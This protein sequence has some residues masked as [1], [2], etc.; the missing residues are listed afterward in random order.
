M[1]NDIACVHFGT[2]HG[3]S[4]VTSIAQLREPAPDTF[5]VV[6]NQLGQHS[7][8]PASLPVPAGWR[9]QSGALPRAGCLAAIEAGWRNI[10][11]ASV[12]APAGDH[13][14]GDAGRG[15]SFVHELFTR[16]AALRPDAVAVAA[17]RARVT[18]RELDESSG[19]LA[20]R[21]R[22]NGVGPEVI[23]GVHLERGIDLITA[24]LGVMKAGGGYL[25]LDPALPAERL[26]MMCAQAGPAVVLTAAPA[27]FPCTSARMLPLGELAS[28]PA[29]GALTAAGP[30]VRPRPDNVCYVIHTSGSTGD[31]KAV[32]V[33]Y[34][35]L[36]SV[37]G[38]LAA[39]YQ[40]GKEDR[41]AQLAAMAFDT[42][43]E[44]MFVA[45]TS[46]ARLTLAPSGTLAP[47]ELLRG[48]E[49]RAIT[50]VDL[51]PAYWHQML[52]LA[53]PDDERLRS[54]R[55]MITGGELADPADCRAALRAAPWARLLNAYGLT[56]TTITS[57]IFDVSGW[58][59]AEP[60]SAV[61]AGRAAGRARIMILDGH[62][63]PVPPGGTGEVY[64]GGP[65]VAR[66][67]LG[68]P[69]LTAERFLPDPAGEPGSRMYRTGDLGRWFADGTL[70]VAGRIDR[71]LKVRGY[72]V[73]P[74][75]IETV[76]AGHPDID[77]VSVVAS[78][79]HAGDTRLVACYTPT[80]AAAQT[81]LHHPR[82]ADLR[83]YLLDRLPSYMVPASF[84]AR[85]PQQDPAAR[86][87]KE[88][89]AV[90]RA[91]RTRT[92]PA[93]HRRHDGR[94]KRE[95]LTP[96]QA[97][98]SALWARLLKL[99]HVDLDDEFF[100]LGGDSLLA[101]EMLAHT[102]ALLGIPADSVRSLTR[103]LLRDPTLR[104]FAAAVEDARAG[105]LSAD[106]DQAE[107]D[108]GSETRLSLKIRD[109][110]A[111][112]A[113]AEG[114]LARSRREPDWRNPAEVL[115]TG[116]AG[117]LGVHLLSELLAATGARVHCLVRARD[118]SA[119][120][121][122]LRHAAARYELPVP[123]GERV[124]PLPGDLAEPRLGLSD[125]RFRELARNVDTI[126]HAGAQ[127]NFIYPY[128]DLRAANV[129]G[130][131]ELI[132]LAAMYRAIPLHYVS[133][134]AVLAGLGVAG[135]R[136]VTEETPLAHPELLRMGY[137]E[138]KYVAEEL[139]RAASGA[140]LPIA[141]YR[142]LDIVGSVRTGAWSTSTEMAAMI[143]F[144]TDTGLAPDIGLPLDF[145]P[146]DTCAAAI[147][148]ISVTA[149]AAG[150]T[151]HLASPEMAPLSTLVGRLRDK[152][153]RIAE[154]PFDDWVSEL[155]QQAARDP[156]H[157]MAAF[158]PLFVGRTAAG[159]TVAEMYLSH[160]FPAY[161]RSNTE[162]ALLG[163]GIAFPP[164]S[165]ELLDRNVERLMQTGYLP[166]PQAGHLTAHAG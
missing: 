7:M 124:L 146:A 130:T 132:R 83:R 111:P 24:V 11:P 39:G 46:G 34:G 90:S 159:L 109:R 21:L 154:I 33:S 162:H 155:A 82:A 114:H 62:L 9:R 97:G 36:A 57:A 51:T 23:V 107:V 65:G 70:E 2:L 54:L 106:G 74:G 138:T 56:E 17:G 116:A 75:E 66:G 153:Y 20:A 29:S 81:A 131:R 93:Q 72:R 8:W 15:E 4:F 128:Q 63:N 115:L 102:D 80:R 88:T 45:L 16:Q 5:V 163:S 32:A 47:S 104:A 164:V 123:R 150:H 99:G 137:V 125:A 68:R 158:L 89:R 98:L 86:P 135:V 161:S 22:E 58:R 52:A 27:S 152:G 94:G 35:S 38:P 120:L 134:T 12:T 26:T 157:P 149:G 142:P 105:R 37:I 61:P 145:V 40:I 110:G 18:Y 55:L 78:S 122:R 60:W 10:A 126:Y 50:V 166:A 133:S 160:V 148:H 28:G 19:R 141:I 1:G 121:S 151:Y 129:T 43:V 53:K 118:E 76:L 96:T 49:R 108:F 92:G 103:R 119:V 14:I 117:F 69:G 165:G 59:Q 91:D 6:V 101:A 30:D 44:Q 95:S 67:Y 41:V 84:V 71:Q 139:L 143:R 144:I 136:E 156:S 25:P 31:P 3:K 147:R 140:G 73:E 79:N 77:Q 64:I 48:I 112:A 42:S 100:A 13:E 87:L 113:S 127:V 85:H